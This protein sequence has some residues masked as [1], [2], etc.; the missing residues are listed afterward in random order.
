MERIFIPDYVRC[1]IDELESNGFEAFIV[2]GCVRDALLGKTPYDYDMTTSATPEETVRVFSH[3]KCIGT[4]LKHGTLTVVSDGHNLEVTTYR[5]DGAYLDNRHPSGV[6]FTKSI[7]EDLA[8]RDLTVNAMAYSDRAGLIDPFN[9]RDDLRRGL[10]RCVGIPEQR[11]DE[12]GLR[13]MRSLRFAATLNFEIEEHTASAI[14]NCREL[15]KNISVERLFSEFSKLVCGEGADRILCGYSDVIGVF[16]PEIL[17]GVGFDQRN[18]H[19]SLN[20][21]DHTLAVVQGCDKNDTVLRLAAFFHDVGKPDAFCADENGIGH[22]PNHAKIGAE[23]TDGI[24]KR[25]HTD[26]ETRCKVVRLVAEH[27]RQIEPSE[28]AA[29]HFLATHSEADARRAIVLNRADRLACAP[30]YRDVTQLD[31]LEEIINAVLAEQACLSLGGLAVRG[32]DIMA[33]GLRGKSVGDV[34]R[35]LLEKVLD[36]E[37]PNEREPLLTAAEKIA[38]NI[39]K[40]R[41]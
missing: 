32:D 22:F 11:F 4:G 26:N 16:I 1:I 9:G 30:E 24:L 36:G 34:L 5:T 14:H 13:I 7:R 23:L 10:I 25:L 15:L 41:T 17:P 37:L 19:H 38:T 40:A 29:R 31:K 18:P 8:R 33:L 3:R 2:G 6:S 39:D 35:A 27:I 12:D 21:F 28:R 20:V